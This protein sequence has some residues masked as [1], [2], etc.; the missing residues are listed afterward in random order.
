MEVSVML[1]FF[2]DSCYSVRWF[3]ALGIFFVLII[4]ILQQF[5][6][7]VTTEPDLLPNKIFPLPGLSVGGHQLS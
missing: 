5:V 4:V 3:G 1:G 2:P 6:R 7:Q